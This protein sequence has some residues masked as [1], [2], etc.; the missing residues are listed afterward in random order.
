[1]PKPA[2]TKDK[3]SKCHFC[4]AD[5]ASACE[6]FFDVWGAHRKDSVDGL[7]LP[8]LRRGECGDPRVSEA[9]A[10]FMACKSRGGVLIESKRK[11]SRP[12][13]VSLLHK[14][15]TE[16]AKTRRC[17]SRPRRKTIRLTA[18]EEDQLVQALTEPQVKGESYEHY[19]TMYDAMDAN[20]LVER[21][22]A[23]SNAT[24]EVLFSHLLANH[25][26][27]VFETEDVAVELVPSTLRAR[28]KCSDIWGGRAPW[29]TKPTQRAETLHGGGTDAASPSA[30][31]SLAVY[32]QL[33]WYKLFTFMLDATTF[34]NVFGQSHEPPRRCFRSRSRVY[35]PRLVK[36]DKSIP[37]ATTLM[38]YLII[39]PFLGIICGPDLVYTGTKLPQSKKAK[40]EQFMKAALETWCARSPPPELAPNR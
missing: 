24:V 18:T 22:V 3:T 35:P 39:H 12:Q 2:I 27:F 10:L 37:Q 7:S 20:P 31:P 15:Y 21:L 1:M 4:V 8:E 13:Y 11:C 6:R 16:W 23:K 36:P 17:T 38:I 5:R 19:Y 30:G 26:D 29:F 34:C 40:V 32:W 14:Y 25:K 28:R 9:Y 33:I